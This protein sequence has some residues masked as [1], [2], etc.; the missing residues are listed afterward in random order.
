MGRLSGFSLMCALDQRRVQRTAPVNAGQIRAAVREH[1][2]PPY[3]ETLAAFHREFVT[4]LKAMISGIWLPGA[5]R[6]LDLACGDGCYSVWLAEQGGPRVEVYAVDVSRDWLGM[7]QA[8]AR[9][10]AAN[11]PQTIAADALCLP[12][13]D[14]S[15]DLAWCAQSLYSLRNPE[16]MLSEISRVLRPGGRLAVM[17]NDSLH[18]LLLPW[19]ASIELKIR[20][21]EL[22]AN[23]RATP[24]SKKFYI[25]RELR[26]RLTAAGF[27]SCGKRTYASTRSGP[28]SGDLRQFVSGYLEALRESVKDDLAA[29]DLQ[30]FDRMLRPGE[31][32]CFF[33]DSH[34]T[35]TSIDHV[36][37]GDKPS[38]PSRDIPGS[39]PEE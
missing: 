38:L 20:A 35:I 17:E 26:R 25:G 7:T 13:A 24:N 8:T 34:I 19:P 15:I 5:R 12:F 6:V 1:H 11:R 23:E 36:A 3:A 29:A 27:G 32:E 9:R 37:W 16:S 14:D 2:L 28:L 30:T 4:E 22:A 18:Q 21:A 31:P 10:S 39:R 33:D